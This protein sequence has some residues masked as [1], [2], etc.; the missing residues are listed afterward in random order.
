MPDDDN[1]N[2]ET[3]DIETIKQYKPGV[4]A[5]YLALGGLPVGLYLYGLNILRRG[6]RW[7]GLLFCA[8]SGAA[9]VLVAFIAATG[10]KATGIGILGIVV[11]LCVY[12]MER[13]PYNLAIENGATPARWWPPLLWVVGIILI[14][15]LII[16]F[17]AKQ[18]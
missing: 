4:I 2:M 7:M 15:F 16:G 13:K 14:V 1:I 12:L 5:A 11:A 17:S 8:L 10:H 9:F 6:Q 18:L 3:K